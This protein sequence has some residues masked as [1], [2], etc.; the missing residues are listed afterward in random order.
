MCNWIKARL[1]KSSIA[2]G[3]CGEKTPIKTTL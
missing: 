1:S 3:V 2:F